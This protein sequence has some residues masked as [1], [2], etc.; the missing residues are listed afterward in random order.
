MVEAP[1]R[2]AAALQVNQAEVSKRGATH[3]VFGL[4]SLAVIG[5]GYGLWRRRG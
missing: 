2:H 4:G 1:N 3:L 5:I